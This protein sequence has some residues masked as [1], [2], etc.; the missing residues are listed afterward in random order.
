[1]QHEIIVQ[2]FKL[3][4][5]KSCSPVGLYPVMTLLISSDCI[6][7]HLPSGPSWELFVVSNLF[8][9]IS[10]TTQIFVIFQNVFPDECGRPSFFFYQ[11][12][13][14]KSIRHSNSNLLEMLLCLPF[15][16][17]PS[18]DRRASWMCVCVQEQN[19]RGALEQIELF[20]Y[21]AADQKSTVHVAGPKSSDGREEL[22][23]C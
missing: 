9:F 22:T 2:W 14:L 6:G 8:H 10:I 17:A 15:L 19:L 16:P 3:E 11:C 23:S 20:L 18:P 21:G 1:M 12:N 13:L 4:A 5:R 7:F